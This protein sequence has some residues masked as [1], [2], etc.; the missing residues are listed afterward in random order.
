MRAGTKI[1]AQ[2]VSKVMVN[3][4]QKTPAMKNAA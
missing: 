4:G 3:Y 2:K 1:E